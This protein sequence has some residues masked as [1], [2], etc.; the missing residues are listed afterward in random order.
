MEKPLD[1]LPR[2][3]SWQPRR[4]RQP[5]GRVRTGG[6]PP[7]HD[8]ITSWTKLGDVLSKKLAHLSPDKSEEVSH[9]EDIT[10]PRASAAAQPDDSVGALRTFECH[11][12]V[13]M[14]SACSETACSAVSL[15]FGCHSDLRLVKRKAGSDR[16]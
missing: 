8:L 11:V 10:T 7:R 13:I 4:K 16:P 15:R 3:G 2:L 14:C 1:W 6:G 5:T 12:R 9:R